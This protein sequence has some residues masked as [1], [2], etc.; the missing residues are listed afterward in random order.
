MGQ[1]G[2][3][4]AISFRQQSTSHGPVSHVLQCG[5]RSGRRNGDELRTATSERDDSHLPRV[6]MRVSKGCER[7]RHRHIRCVI[8][9]GAS[10][11]APCSR[12][13]QVCHLDPRFQF[14]DVH[15]VYQKSNGTAA[16]FDLVW[17]AEQVWVDVSQPVTFVHE[18]CE[19]SKPDDRVEPAH[20]SVVERHLSFASP[21][22][23]P[24]GTE[25]AASMAEE[26]LIQHDH[27]H[28]LS[29][30]HHSGSLASSASHDSTT[31]SLREASLMRCFIQKIAPWADICDPQSHFSTVVPRRS[32]Q[33]PMV[34]KAVLA[35]TARHDAIL[36]GQSDWEASTYHGQCLELLIPALDRLD[37]DY[38]ENLLIT[39]VILRI[40]EELEN[41][42]DQ[43]FHLLGSNRLI[44]LMSRSASSRGIAEAVSWQFLRQAIYSSIVQYQHLQLDLRNYERSSMFQRDDDAA[45]ANMII[46]HCAHIIQLCRVLPEDPI[47]EQSW[48]KVADDV[49]E[50]YRKKP[51]TWQPLRYQDSNV[52]ENRPFPEIWMMSAPAVVGMQ[53]YHAACIFLT[54]SDPHSRRMR[55]FE[56]ARTR[57]LAERKI[58]SHV[59]SVIGLSWSNESVHNA[60]FMACHLL[61]RF[62][63]CLQHPV[64]QQGSLTFLSRVEKLIGWRTTWIRSELEHQWGELADFDPPST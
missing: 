11:C 49:D 55:E 28:E 7:C 4:V 29:P 17:D 42:E 35:L 62:G 26:P 1:Y 9:P 38:D 47:D 22:E 2:P 33:V 53:Y 32:L 18:T 41:S 5:E 12:L 58:A 16:R 3:V 50:W 34:L 30:F 24:H 48:A 10:A 19:D 20:S 57:R 40:Y 37:Q 51:I 45:F 27:S 21:V 61:H 8:P 46:F 23:Q 25:P 6:L 36:V 31:L 44:N 39:V 14:K 43:K 59:I 13:G 63:Y 56:M 54:M 60:Y 52:A 64:E 15:H